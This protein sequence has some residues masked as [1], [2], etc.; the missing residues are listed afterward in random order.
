MSQSW[1][2]DIILL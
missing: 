2:E 1:A